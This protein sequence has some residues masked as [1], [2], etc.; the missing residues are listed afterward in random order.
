MEYLLPLVGG[1]TLYALLNK[2]ECYT[3]TYYDSPAS[4][5]N[6]NSEEEINKINNFADSESTGK[7]YSNRISKAYDT[8]MASSMGYPL[9]KA[10]YYQN[11]SEE[12]FVQEQQKQ[13]SKSINGIPLKDYYETY[14]KQT[15]EKGEW[16]LN[17]YMPEGTKQYEENSQVSQKLGIYT[18]SRQQ[19]D[20]N[21]LGIPNRRETKNLFTPEETITGYGYQYGESGYGPGLEITREKEMEAMRVRI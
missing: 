12:E 13:F 15:L 3:Q 5:E 19:D 10:N 8:N 6:S 17:Q 4:L 18:G 20:R 2:K 14:I 11:Q 7:V 9:D 21:M 16:Y 1:I